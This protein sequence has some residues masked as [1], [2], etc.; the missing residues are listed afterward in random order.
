MDTNLRKALYGT[1]EPPAQRRRFQAG[2]LSV[3]FEAGNLRYIRFGGAEV[4]RGIAFLVRDTGWGTYQPAITGLFTREQ[5]SRFEIRYQARCSGPEGVFIYQAM[6]EGRASG[7]LLF[8]CEGAPVGNLPV[9]RVG[10]VV[11]HPIEG[12]AGQTIEV[13]H[14]DGS[15]E[16]AVLPAAVAPDQPILDIRALTHAVAPGTLARVQMEGDAYEMED[17]RNWTD[18]SF[19]AYIRPL[20]KPRP[21]VVPAGE[22]Q[23]Q[24]ITV[25]LKGPPPVPAMAS[26]G[27][28]VPVARW[29]AWNHAGNRAGRGSRRCCR[30]VR[31]R[32]PL[33]GHWSAASHS[34][35]RCAGRAGYRGARPIRRPDGADGQRANA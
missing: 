10:F 17:Q 2:P 24:S 31:G 15:R 7:T 13:E 25:T 21:F 18:A 27:K 5:H 1:D 19:K 12:M 29:S 20:A 16:V 30:R 3:E 35:V 23:V 22:K 33:A 8:A 14:T 4:L 11:L 9:N 6:I 28:A 32:R 34:A 26:S